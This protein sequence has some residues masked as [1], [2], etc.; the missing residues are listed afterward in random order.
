M[1]AAEGRTGGLRQLID[2]LIRTRLDVEDDLEALRQEV[3]ARY[4]AIIRVN[5]ERVLHDT[6]TILSERLA[7]L[8]PGSSVRLCWEPHSLTL[9]PPRV[10]AEIVEA[11]FPAEVGRQGH[12]VQRAY[13]LALLQALV[14]ARSAQQE[15]A[16]RP[17][18]V[19]AIEEPELYQH[20]VRARYLAG[21]LRRLATDPVGPPT[22]VL[23][24]THSPFFVSVDSV[25]SIRL[26]RVAGGDSGFP[27]SVASQVD[28]DAAAQELWAAHGAQGARWTASSL[29]PR[30]RPMV[31]TP[32]SEG[33]FGAAV[34]LV[35]GEE[36]RAVLAAAAAQQGLDL[37]QRGIALIPV[38]GKA[39]LDRAVVLYRQLG[40]PTYVLFDVDR[41]RGRNGNPKANRALLALFGHTPEDFPATQVQSTFAC[42]ADTLVDAVRDE[43][44]DAVDRCLDQ[45][46][47]DFGFADDRWKNS[48]VL[49]QAI[50]ALAQQ[51]RTSATLLAVLRQVVDLVVHAGPSA[52]HS[53]LSRVVKRPVTVHADT[54]S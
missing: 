16:T 35:E 52:A 19:L 23:Y 1:D 17:L 48:V 31:E 7:A 34:V 38:A 53:S 29:R 54:A 22:Q 45:A 37:S 20:P 28:L 36:D 3:D 6:S 49:A 39:N 11:E 27:E 18:L 10:R 25:E 14:E 32:V 5:G 40:I 4:Q 9:E 12:G 51:G 26:L 13:V 43:L 15:A 46:C 42:F 41:R 2:L 44:G 8:A 21:V 47:A 33:F 24:T 50:D 30:L